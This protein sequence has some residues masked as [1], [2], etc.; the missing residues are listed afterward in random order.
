[1]RLSAILLTAAVALGVLL[2]V[3]NTVGLD[4]LKLVK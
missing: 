1:M 3:Q 4:R 2:V